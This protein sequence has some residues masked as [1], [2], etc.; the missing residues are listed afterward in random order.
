MSVSP[1]SLLLAVLLWSQEM[2]A[3][4]AP[5]PL[6]E[7]QVV[8]LPGVQRRI[9]H[10]AVDVQGRRLFVAALGNGTLE[11]LDL[12]SGKRV[13]SV[14]GLKEPQGVAYLPAV[15]RVAVATAGGSLVSYDDRE[16]KPLASVAGLD[17]ADNLRVDTTAN[18]LYLGYGDG[19]LGV[20]DPGTLKRL[21]DVKLPGHPESFRLEAAGSRI[22]VNVPRTREVL[23]V[24]R[25]RR[26]IV[27]HIA[28]GG[29]FSRNYPMYLDETHHRL[30][31]GVRSPARL[32]V[33]DT[34]SG[35]KLAA[36]PCV[37]DT[38]DLFYDPRD[39]VYVIGGEGF[40]DVFDASPARK[41]TLLA[42]IATRSGARTGLWS[43]ELSQLFVAWPARSGE[44]AAVHVLSAVDAK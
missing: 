42:H 8:P 33:F 15:H 1:W 12:A 31:V 13:R 37:G 32:L 9:D 21:G 34:G 19:A 2:S 41:Y 23:I 7:T 20:F 44:E 4:A 36:L 28:L 11:V 43:D 17:D 35:K 26:A 22:F 27:N 40:V 6:A 29:L 14:G 5:A 3:L 24:D 10:L 16:F 39:R 25:D 38:D 18:L 30:F